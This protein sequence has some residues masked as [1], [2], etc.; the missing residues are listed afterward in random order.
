M[1]P[2]GQSADLAVG[3]D[4]G[5][6]RVDLVKHLGHVEPLLSTHQE[7][8]VREGELHVLWVT[9]AMA[10]R[11][12]KR[13]WE[14]GRKRARSGLRRRRRRLVGIAGESGPHSRVLQLLHDEAVD[15][16]RHVCGDLA[17]RESKLAVEQLV[18]VAQGVGKS[19]LQPSS[20][21]AAVDLKRHFSLQSLL[22][23]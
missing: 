18:D 1:D 19:V 9:D 7:V 10:R 6:V 2:C 5:V 3:K 13:L 20:C 23:L 16:V 22:F 12:V 15:H 4:A 11:L 14:S 8:E 17:G 21:G